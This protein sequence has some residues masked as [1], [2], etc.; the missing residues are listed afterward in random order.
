MGKYCTL[1]LFLL[2]LYWFPFAKTITYVKHVDNIRHFNDLTLKGKYGDIICNKAKLFI[3]HEEAGLDF[4]DF[5]RLRTL[6]KFV[7]ET[8][9]QKTDISTFGIEDYWAGAETTC[10]LKYGDCEDLS[11]VFC[12]IASNIGYR[13]KPVFSSDHV[14]V[15]W[16]NKGFMLYRKEKLGDLK[17][18]AAF[19]DNHKLLYYYKQVTIPYQCFIFWLCIP[20]IFSFKAFRRYKTFAGK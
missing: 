19:L 17:D 5:Q 13:V 7:L 14:W 12:M 10:E 4:S 20:L 11:F 9:S 18:L 1:V 15:E 16:E 8:F 3:K 2:G 6:E